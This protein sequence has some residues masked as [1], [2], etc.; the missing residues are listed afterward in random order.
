M[1]VYIVFLILRFFFLDRIS[2]CNI[3]SLI[4]KAG[5]KLRDPAASASASSASSAGIKGMQFIYNFFRALAVLPR[6]KLPFSV[7]TN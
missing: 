7:S 5:L 4:D 2:L 1:C 3:G 6:L